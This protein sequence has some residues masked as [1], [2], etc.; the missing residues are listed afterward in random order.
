MAGSNTGHLYKIFFSA[1]YGV[2]YLSKSFGNL[3]KLFCSITNIQFYGD[4]K[5][6]S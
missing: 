4:A 5:P 6:Q 1:P 2:Y 3:E